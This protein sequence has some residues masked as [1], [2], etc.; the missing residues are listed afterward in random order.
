MI[1][2]VLNVHVLDRLRLEWT[3]VVNPW[4]WL[5]DARWLKRRRRRSS[6]S[7]FSITIIMAQKLVGGNA[8]T[9]SRSVCFSFAE[10]WRCATIA[11][12]P[13]LPN[14]WAT[15]KIQRMGNSSSSS[16]SA[17]NYISGM[18]F[19]SSFFHT[20]SPRNPQWNEQRECVCLVTCTQQQKKRETSEM[21]K[22]WAWKV[23]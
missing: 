1:Q 18:S 20:V 7:P 11:K 4:N 10:R 6:R 5:N 14:W 2:G 21:R 13:W 17:E 8:T 23:T 19:S 16:S 3:I 12:P 22:K 9:N 15:E